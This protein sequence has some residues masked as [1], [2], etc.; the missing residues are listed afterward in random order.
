[1]GEEFFI[2]HTFLIKSNAI[3]KLN[4]NVYCIIASIYC[5]GS[6]WLLF[7]DKLCFRNGPKCIIYEE[8]SR[9]ILAA[10]SGRRWT[11]FGWHTHTH[12]TA[13]T[14]KKD[15]DMCEGGGQPGRR[16]RIEMLCMQ[17]TRMKTSLIFRPICYLS[18]FGRYLNFNQANFFAVCINIMQMKCALFRSN[19][20]DNLWRSMLPLRPPHR[21][22]V[23]YVCH[24]IWCF[25]RTVLIGPGELGRMMLSRIFHVLK[26]PNRQL[27]AFCLWFIREAKTWI[28]PE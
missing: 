7:T 1:M 18:S 20:L 17:N 9:F 13:T 15:S 12:K 21:V 6:K 16:S 4:V 14:Q 2:F 3:K 26:S 25:M 5:G 22:P 23:R 28:V 24:S 10:Q 8:Q 27:T 19:V 11:S